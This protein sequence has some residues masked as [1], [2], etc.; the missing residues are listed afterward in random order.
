[1]AQ[2]VKP[3][4]DGYHTATPYLIVDGGATAIEFYQRAFGAKEI[5]RVPAPGGKVGHA[6]I[7]IGHSVI[8]LADEAPEMDARSPKSYG[9]SPVSILLY[10]ADVDTQFA[11]AVAAGGTATRPV[12][13]QFYGDRS[14]SLKDPFGHTWHISTHKED[15][16]PEEIKKRMDA[17]KKS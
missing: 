17:M 16:S 5:M 1:M 15:V 13:D 3:V 12:A 14:G 10:V 9:G 4:P 7:K 11:Q 2:N 8:M 6:E